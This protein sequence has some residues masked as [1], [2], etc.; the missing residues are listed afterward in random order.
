MDFQ[1][2]KYFYFLKEYGELC[3]LKSGKKI[4]IKVANK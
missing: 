2:V 4:P 1:R 3:D